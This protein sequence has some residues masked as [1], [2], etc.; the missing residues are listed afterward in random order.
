MVTY[1][2]TYFNG[3][4]SITFPENPAFPVSVV[5]G[6]MSD[7]HDYRHVML[8]RAIGDI[9]LTDYELEWLLTFDDDV[10]QHD[11]LGDALRN[12]NR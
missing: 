2:A 6:S 5:C 3:R 10:A 8:R 4:L 12:G 11:A 9:V 7:P 1:N